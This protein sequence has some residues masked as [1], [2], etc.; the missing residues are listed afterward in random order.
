[1]TGVFRYL[2]KHHMAPTPV[3]GGHAWQNDGQNIVYDRKNKVFRTWALGNPDWSVE[4]GFPNTSWISYTGKTIDMMKPDT[5]LIQGEASLNASFWSGSC[6]VDYGNHLGRGDGVAYYYVSGPA[7]YLQGITLLIADELGEVPL[8]LGMCC[9]PD[10][11][12]LDLRDG[13]RDFRDCRVFWDEDHNQLIMA[14]TIGRGFLFLKS[15]NGTDWT[16]LSSFYGPGTG[17]DLVECPN[18]YKLSIKDVDGVDTGEKKW[19]LLGASQGKDANYNI[20]YENCTAWIGDWDGVKFTPES[21]VPQILDYGPDSYAAVAGRKDE[22]SEVYFNSWLSNW[23]YCLDHSPYRGFQNLQGYPRTCWLQEEAD[24]H[25]RVYSMP[26]EPTHTADTT[27]NK[28]PDI[29]VNK[30]KSLKLNPGDAYKVDLTLKQVNGVWPKSITLSFHTGESDRRKFHTDFVIS[31]DGKVTFN[32][33]NAGREWPCYPNAPKPEW[34]KEYSI[35]ASVGVTD[36][37]EIYVS[38]IVDTSS[39]EAFF[40]KGQASMAGL[41]FPP[42]GCTGFEVNASSPV[43]VISAVTSL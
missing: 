39:V 41:C 26:V 43:T 24:G 23:C 38:A 18:F 22:N 36:G 27:V 15:L 11:V 29:T 33:L 7:P 13:G 31:D 42:E 20:T 14:T 17:N 2:P 9:P 37:D 34:T 40:N 8:S 5:M 25:L 28:Y 3:P 12:P 30:N 19:V 4:S 16:P 6:Y 1:M 10:I 35:P 21:I 32:R